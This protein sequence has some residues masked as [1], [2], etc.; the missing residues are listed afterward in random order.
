VR[1]LQCIQQVEGTV[2]RKKYAGIKETELP[3]VEFLR[4]THTGYKIN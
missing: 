4:N 3:R 1:V 2:R